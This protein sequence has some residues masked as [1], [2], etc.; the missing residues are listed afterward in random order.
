MAGSI[1]SSKLTI[2][3]TLG[4]GYGSPLSI[5]AAGEVDNRYGYGVLI[6]NGT[7][8]TVTNSGTVIGSPDGIYLEQSG[9]TIINHSLIEGSFAAIKVGGLVDG[10]VQVVNAGT[11]AGDFG[12][13]AS[14]SGVDL[15]NS[16]LISATNIGVRLGAS[17]VTNTGTIEGSGGV[18]LAY[19][20]LTNSV[21]GLITATAKGI[22]IQGGEAFNYGSISGLSGPG[23]QVD[24]APG[25]DGTLVNSGSI[26]G[27]LAGVYV[28]SGSFLNQGV[29]SG[30]MAGLA[31]EIGGSAANYGTISG[32]KYGAAL[33]GNTN[34]LGGAILSNSGSILGG[35]IGVTIGANGSLLNYGYI[36]GPDSGVT[37]NGGYL[38]NAASGRIVNAA[39]GIALGGSMAVA[40]N[41]GTIDALNDGISM[42]SGLA[43]NYGTVN[44]V[45]DGAV[46]S[47]GSLVNYGTMSGG[48]YGVAGSG[49][50]VT[51]YG[52]ISGS[53]YGVYLSH[54]VLT[55]S[56]TISGG[57]DAVRGYSITLAV[58]PGA[59]FVGTVANMSGKGLL[60]LTGTGSRPSLT[61]IGSQIKG[62]A[63]ISF[64]NGASWSI[65]GD[66]AGLATGQTITGFSAGDTIVLDGFSASS[67]VYVKNSGLTLSSGTGKAA[68]DI[69]GNFTTGSFHVTESGSTTTIAVTCFAAGT[70]IATPAGEVAVEALRIGDL[71]STLHGGP[72]PVKW[73]GRRGYDGRFIQGNKAILPICIKAGAIMEGVPA[74]DLWLSPGHAISIDGML[75]HAGRL[76]N[77]VSVIQAEAVEQV[78]YYHIELEDHEILLAENCPAESFAGEHFRP[79][80]QNS[81][82]FSL[83]YAGQTAPELL[84]QPRLDHG[85]HLHA[86]Q[87]RLRE[88]AGLRESGETGPLR[89]YV[90]RSGSG[91]CFGWAQDTAR[92]ETPVCLDIL[93]DGRRIGRVLANLYREDV[94][95]AGYGNG[96][97]GF[98]FRLPPD[99]IGQIEVRRS[100]D[101]AVL[102]MAAPDAACERAA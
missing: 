84:C 40:L 66:E 46:L 34:A 100:V 78:H 5:T 61:G 42:T 89:G 51:N 74:H 44:G 54:A 99:A 25:A 27:D 39:I 36:S 83:L 1:V 33:P 60:E 71:V 48:T 21:S 93:H 63:Q 98:E 80:F 91:L 88:R 30:L 55:N 67:E 29:V 31:V 64:T 24:D 45:Y 18:Y 49:G 90:D 43:E 2:G 96:Y 12:I 10:G 56:G 95:K 101:G 92:P 26:S 86:I 50:S 75:V 58:E 76:I 85:F 13:V 79:Q 14:G 53:S 87:R 82:E 73:I 65:E 32:Y 16:G 97:Q 62:F 69:L 11:L 81:A 28:G 57:L 15:A 94:A 38:T 72:R 37:I 47:G 17:T 4:Y 6:P 35:V 9:A 59:Q 19:G 77:G 20:M 68:L 3:V 23:A 41:H 70:R 8:G 22:Y 52:L 7:V 102:E